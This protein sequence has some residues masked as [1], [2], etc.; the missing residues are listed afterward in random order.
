MAIPA[1]VSIITLGVSDFERSRSFYLA[2]GWKEMSSSVPGVI[3]W[4]KTAET[5]LGIHPYEDLA[6]DGRMAVGERNGFGGV[7]FAINL[8]SDAAVVAAFEEAVAAGAS[9]L[10]APE[11]AIFGGLSAYI[12]DPD[13]YPWELAHNPSF[14]LGKDGRISIP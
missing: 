13:G 1:R 10:K 4:F 9:I 12:G 7:T 5:Y 2:L 6:E 11:Q 3:S 8:E 14:P